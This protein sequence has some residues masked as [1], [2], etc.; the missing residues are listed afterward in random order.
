MK[1]KRWRKTEKGQGKRKP[2]GRTQLISFVYWIRASN[3]VGWHQAC[4]SNTALARQHQPPPRTITTINFSKINWFWCKG[5][6][7]CVCVY[8]QY[9]NVIALYKAGNI[10][11]RYMKPQHDSNIPRP[12]LHA[13]QPTTSA[14]IFV[15]TIFVTGAVSLVHVVDDQKFY[16][17]KMRLK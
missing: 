11:V 9:I 14:D 16:V 1:N 4:D 15:F 8:V 12:A 5:V 2:F 17:N 10:C 13:W 3:Y 7:V 6:C